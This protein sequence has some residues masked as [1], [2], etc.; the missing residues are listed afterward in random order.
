MTVVSE[1]CGISQETVRAGMRDVQQGAALATARRVRQ[2]GGGRKQ[3]REKDPKLV[4]E[5][6]K[7]VSPATRG[8]PESPV[9]WTSKSLRRLA[10]ELT[11]A[12]HPVSADVVGD[13]L[14][15]QSS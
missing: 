10:E 9:R 2:P 6:E 13:L 8:D 15:E 14:R 1:A 3:L 5:L 11:A 12:G 4:K 7:L